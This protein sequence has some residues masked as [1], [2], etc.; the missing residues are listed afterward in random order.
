MTPLEKILQKYQITKFED[1]GKN[2]FYEIYK[3]YPSKII[4]K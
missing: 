4:G 2:D 1:Y 3:K